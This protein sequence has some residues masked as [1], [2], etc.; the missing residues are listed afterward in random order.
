MIDS[1]RNLGSNIVLA[2]GEGYDR[3]IGRDL[4]SNARASANHFACVGGV[5]VG[6]EV[7]LGNFPQKEL[8]VGAWICPTH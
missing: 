8:T 2:L 1:L 3:L 5:L 4:H 7:E 6:N